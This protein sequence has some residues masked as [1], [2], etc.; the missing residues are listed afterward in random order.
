MFLCQ[1][2]NESTCH[3]LC[4]CEIVKAFWDTFKTW[5]SRKIN[6]EVNLSDKIIIHSAFSKCSLLNNL[7]VLAKYYIYKNKFY[8][9]SL[10]IRGFEA[11]V[12]VNFEN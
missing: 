8:K 12:K 2:E 11:F 7:I 4:T 5:A 9:K 1:K 6:T 3:L 10:N